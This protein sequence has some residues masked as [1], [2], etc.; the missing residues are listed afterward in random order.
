MNKINVTKE[1]EGLRID[2]W[3]DKEVSG[4][5]RTKWQEMIKDGEVFVNNEKTKAN[6]KVKADDVISYEDPKP[7]EMK[8]EAVKMPLDI[9]YEDDDL[10][11]VNK[12]KGLVVHPGAG[13]VEPTLVS[14][15]L[16]HCQ[17]LSGINGKL[18]PGIVHRIDKDTTGLLVVA[19]NDK[20]HRFLA[21]QLADK[22]LSRKYLALVQGVIEPDNGIIDAPIGRDPHERTKMAIRADHSKPAVTE[23][24]VRKRF[25]EY[26]LIECH[27]K[28]GRTHQIRVHLK[29]IGHPIVGDQ[30]YGKKNNDLATSQLL[31]A[32]EISF[33]HPTTKKVMTFNADLPKEFA[34][35]LEH[36]EEREELFK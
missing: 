26:T 5:S 35:I 36:L 6:Y 19:K 12:P 31:H 27:L 13:T 24:I 34:D 3:L 7:K 16:A 11:V 14:G 20:A 29:Y 4:Q 22:T 15:L 10:L 18:R 33:I 2:S 17:S 32:Y 21:S 23:F 25:K 1:N 28:T 8:V 9:I 30:Q